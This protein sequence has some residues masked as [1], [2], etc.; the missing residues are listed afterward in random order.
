[1]FAADRICKV[2]VIYKSSDIYNKSIIHQYNLQTTAHQSHT[3]P[4]K[5]KQMMSLSQKVLLMCESRLFFTLDVFT[6]EQKRIESKQHNT[7][8]THQPINKMVRIESDTGHA[9]RLDTTT[10]TLHEGSGNAH[11]NT[12][13][14]IAAHA[15][16]SW[17]S[18]SSK[19]ELSVIDA[20]G[21][22]E[23]LA[24][25]PGQPLNMT[26]DTKDRWL[27]IGTYERSIYLWDV[28]NKRLS[29]VL[30]VLTEPRQLRF[31]DDGLEIF[32]G[33]AFWK[34]TMV[35]SNEEASVLKRTGEWTNYRVCR[36]THQVVAVVPFPLPNSIW[37]PD[38][39]CKNAVTTSTP[40][41]K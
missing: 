25:I 41:K 11:D 2:E 26:L 3:L 4:C 37:A 27:A 39:Q 29:R 7:Q 21:I 35:T 18:V 1:M 28:K 15:K 17:F 8:M 10:W 14:T 32:D 12:T 36:D 30:S 5:I 20:T 9:I 31:Q 19:G 13:I 23:K 22:A 34:H 16:P 33:H 40:H 38:S 6:G 24:D